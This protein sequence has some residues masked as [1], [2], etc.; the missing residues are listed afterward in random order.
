[1]NKHFSL[2]LDLLR[3][4]A[5]TLVVLSHFSQLGMVG[6]AMQRLLP[7]LGREAVVVFFV[8]S[9]FVIAYT[10]SVKAASLRQYAVARCARIYS[11][12]LPV[13]L[14]TLAAVAF[15]VLVCDKSVAGS[16]QL[17]KLYIYVPLHLLF[18]GELWNLSETPAW[19]L[20][21]WSLSYEVWYYVL[22]GALFYA[23]GKVRV[24]LVLVILAVMGHKLWLL[25]PVWMSGVML[26]RHQGR[27]HMSANH[28]RLAWAITILALVLYKTSGSDV[29]LR[30]LGGAIW[31]F[32]GL[33]LGS[34]DRYLADYVVG[35]LVCL[36]F[37]FARQ[38]EFSALARVAAPIRTL[39]AY[40]F[41]LYLIHTPVIGMWQAF[42]A[43]DNTSWSDVALLSLCIVLACYLF[44]FV[45]ERRKAWFQHFFAYLF[46]IRA[47]KSV[48]HI[49]H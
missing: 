5:A 36:N 22:F 26:Y 37:L 9:G 21:Y 41:T 10:T 35:A 8:L 45:T 13:L 14:F 11:V 20:P 7:Q 6:G 43:H 31:P 49:Q 32:P 29:M 25:L 2:Y 12:V 19:L 34:A 39:A 24:A 33:K 23:R 40:T 42:Y 47:R 15:A 46:A 16:Y 44:G 17:N 1:M 30:A 27:L 3:F 4:S 38:A 28:A 18:A 48:P